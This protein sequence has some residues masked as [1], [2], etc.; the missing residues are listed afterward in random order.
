V[1]VAST[2]SD[3]AQLFVLI[4]RKS[5]DHSV[6]ANQLYMFT[7]LGAKRIPYEV[8]DASDPANADRR[9]ELFAL[10]GHQ[11]KF[12]Q[13]F[14]KKDDGSITFWGTWERFVEANEKGKLSKE[15]RIAKV[16]TSA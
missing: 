4:S 16:N 12:P 2:N 9:D 1:S 6:V 11:N 8:L 5:L 3:K 15:F 13:F 10:S 7:V 14:L